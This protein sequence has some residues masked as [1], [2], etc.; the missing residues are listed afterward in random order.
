M[1]DYPPQA[2]DRPGTAASAPAS[3]E[4]EAVVRV[5]VI[6]DD[7]A[8]GLVL[9]RAM[10]RLGY[11]A[12]VAADGTRGISTFEADPGAYGLVLLDFKLPG[13][14]SGTVHQKLR[15]R[16]PDLPVVLMS[17]YN[18]Q[19]ALEKSAGMDLAG[20]LHK[21][22]NMATLSEALRLALRD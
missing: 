1:N 5:L 21:P 22:F 19:E 11:K 3:Q 6:D 4:R 9:S 17:G 14:D 8:V 15:E 12:D 10:A 18:K 16:R 7:D 20:F 13:M 2:V